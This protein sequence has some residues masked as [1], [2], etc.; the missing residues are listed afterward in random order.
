MACGESS[1]VSWLEK[2][3][4]QERDEISSYSN[5]DPDVYG[6]RQKSMSCKTTSSAGM[7]GLWKTYPVM[8]RGFFFILY[9]ALLLMNFYTHAH[10]PNHVLGYRDVNGPSVY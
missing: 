9:E 6:K 8:M 5:L 3:A 4:S 10:V 7:G 2:L 1:H